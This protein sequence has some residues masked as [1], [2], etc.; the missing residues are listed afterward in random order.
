MLVRPL[1]IHPSPAYLARVPPPYLHT[2]GVPQPRREFRRAG[3]RVY[4]GG[5]EN[6]QS[7]L[8]IR[9]FGGAEEFSESSCAPAGA[10]WRALDS[11]A[12]RRAPALSVQAA[13]ISLR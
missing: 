6:S 13:V 10:A 11:L 1:P 5:A 7:I 8:S 3:G 9:G 4:L 12:G 2:R